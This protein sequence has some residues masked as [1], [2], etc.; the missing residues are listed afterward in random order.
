MNFY[1]L[2]NKIADSNDRRIL[3]E[4][5]NIVRVNLFNEKKSNIIIIKDRCVFLFVSIFFPFFV[6]PHLSNSTS[7]AQTATYI[8]TPTSGSC[9][10]ASFTLTVTLNPGAWLLGPQ[11]RP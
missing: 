2:L 6:R 7:I 3:K 10:G 8:V 9:T 1:Y 4:V 11:A 5:I